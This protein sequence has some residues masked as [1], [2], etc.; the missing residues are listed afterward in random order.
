MSVHQF[1]SFEFIYGIGFVCILCSVLCCVLLVLAMKLVCT[2]RNVN[3][4]LIQALQYRMKPMWRQHKTR[5]KWKRKYELMMESYFILP[6]LSSRILSASLVNDWSFYV[7]QSTSIQ[8]MNTK[9][10]VFNKS[11]F[12]I[13]NW[14]TN[15][16]LST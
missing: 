8:T 4:I 1:Q 9:G 5:K 16:K 2:A 10:R 6:S 3:V 11:I 7:V 13:Q 14:H 15:D 12:S